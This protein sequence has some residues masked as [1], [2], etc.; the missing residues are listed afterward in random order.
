[1]AER[2]E[3]SS[4]P[5]ARS[6]AWSRSAVP[7]EMDLVIKRGT[8]PG[9]IVSAQAPS[10]RVV[11][12]KVPDV[13]AAQPGVEI[14]ATVP[15]GYDG[16]SVVNG[17][18][19][20]W[21]KG[22]GM[23]GRWDDADDGGGDK[24]EDEEEDE[25]EEEAEEEAEEAV[26]EEA[27]EAPA[28][29]ERAAAEQGGDRLGT[30]H[31]PRLG[32]RSQVAGSGRPLLVVRNE[33][34]RKGKTD[35]Y[36]DPVLPPPNAA[37]PATQ[38][39]AAVRQALEDRGWVYAPEEAVELMLYYENPD[40]GS[41]FPLTDGAYRKVFSKLDLPRPKLQLRPKKTLPTKVE[42]LDYNDPPGPR[43]GTLGGPAAKNVK[44]VHVEGRWQR[45]DKAMLK[46]K[47]CGKLCSTEYEFEKHQAKHLAAPH[48]CPWPGCP[49][50]NTRRGPLKLHWKTHMS[51]DYRLCADGVGRNTETG[52][53]GHFHTLG[54]EAS[55]RYTPELYKVHSELYALIWTKHKTRSPEDLNMYIQA[56][57]NAVGNAK[58]M[59]AEV[60]S[61]GEEGGI[62]G[63]VDHKV[64]Q[65]GEKLLDELKPGNEGDALAA[66]AEVPQET[67]GGT[68]PWLLRQFGLARHGPRLESEGLDL[69][70]LLRLLS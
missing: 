62:R 39:L 2:W 60:H 16:V 54:I 24:E 44:R 14:V 18:V 23:R 25:E 6:V 45:S 42:P 3:R 46:C 1:M 64:V 26:V 59:A 31:K 33:I 47:L 49:Y 32:P 52:L 50:R 5:G 17:R 9:D 51:Q 10:G 22:R 11:M 53:I 43:L 70:K 29:A 7:E 41:W 56:V 55:G 34:V 65:A 69:E 58:A 27:E 8:K 30:F 66:E 12:V 35:H 28:E 38:L 57:E 13:V 4:T 48:S 61:E 63:I 37:S 67:D 36:I 20:V 21:R 15:V 19:N 68:L 40:D